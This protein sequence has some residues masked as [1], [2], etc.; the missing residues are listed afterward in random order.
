VQPETALPITYRTLS[1][2]IGE[3]QQQKQKEAKKVKQKVKEKA[4]VGKSFLPLMALMSSVSDYTP[5][6]GSRTTLHRVNLADTQCE[7][8]SLD[9]NGI[10]STF[11]SCADAS[12]STLTK[13]FPKNRR[14]AASASMDVTR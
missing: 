9:W 1:I 14:S 5:H 12:P 11:Q 8:V 13:V 6:M 3:G 4:V 2:E 7:K 10:L